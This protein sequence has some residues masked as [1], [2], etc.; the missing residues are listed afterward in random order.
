[1]LLALSYHPGPPLTK[2]SWVSRSIKND[3]GSRA[4]LAGGLL[5]LWLPKHVAIWKTN[6]RRAKTA[7]D[8]WKGISARS[9]M[10]RGC[11]VLTRFGVPLG[12]LPRH[13][14]HTNTNT[15]TL[16]PLQQ[17][18]TE[19]KVFHDG[20]VTFCKCRGCFNTC[21]V[22]SELREDLA[23]WMYCCL[24]P[25]FFD[26]GK[27]IMIPWNWNHFLMAKR[28]FDSSWG[29][30]LQLTSLLFPDVYCLCHTHCLSVT[31]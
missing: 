7:A 21:C 17:Q 22:A 28:V 5:M 16:H 27:T 10:L 30:M 19:G 29:L 13:P 31:I 23:C 9:F 24:L 15:H 18:N 26:S 1:M 11:G 6:M 2:P 8:A 12:C 4:K 3:A 20:I 25:L 14:P